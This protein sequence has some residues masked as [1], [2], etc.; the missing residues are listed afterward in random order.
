MK[1]QH[2]PLYRSSAYSTRLQL[3]HVW[4][5]YVTDSD[6]YYF[7]EEVRKMLQLLSE[8]NVDEESYVGSGYLNDDVA[9]DSYLDANIT[10]YERN[11]S[12]DEVLQDTQRLDP[13]DY[14]LDEDLYAFSLSYKVNLYGSYHKILSTYAAYLYLHHEDS[15]FTDYMEFYKNKNEIFNKLDP[16]HVVAYAVSAQHGVNIPEMT[17]EELHQVLLKRSVKEIEEL[18]N[19]LAKDN[20]RFIQRILSFH[21]GFS[22]GDEILDIF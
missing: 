21:S 1:K 8:N 5:R 13:N 15:P 14:K 19:L 20:E 6:P 18:D 22:S 16:A 17:T 3:D 4:V 11:F 9:I 7:K 2:V 10:S 12:I